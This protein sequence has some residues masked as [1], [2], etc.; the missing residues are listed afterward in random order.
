VAAEDV[1]VIYYRLILSTYNT[2]Y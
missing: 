1:Q 2:S